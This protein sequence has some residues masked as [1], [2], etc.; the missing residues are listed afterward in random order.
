MPRTDRVEIVH[1]HPVGHRQ[2][3]QAARIARQMMDMYQVD[4]KA[5]HESTQTT[6]PGQANPNLPA[7]RRFKNPVTCGMH[8]ETMMSKC[9]GVLIDQ[10]AHG[11]LQSA[12]TAMKQVQDC[13]PPR[14]DPR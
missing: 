11:Q 14:G 10:Q 9:L 13:G 2:A 7:T 12:A 3:Q 5:P 6:P 1:R 4:P 8:E